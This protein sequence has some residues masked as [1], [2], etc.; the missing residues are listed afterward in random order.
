MYYLPKGL[1]DNYNVSINEKYF[2][3]QPIDSDTK[4]HEEIRKLRTG[5]RWILYYWIFVRLE[6]RQKSL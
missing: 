2:Y 1:I 5:H 4:W 6:V 3:Y